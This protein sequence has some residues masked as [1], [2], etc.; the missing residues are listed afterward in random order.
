MI[1]Q[2]LLLHL[3]HVPG[4][5]HIVS[6]KPADAAEAD[7]H[8]FEDLLMRL[9]VRLKQQTQLSSASKLAAAVTATA[10]LIEASARV[11]GFTANRGAAYL[12]VILLHAFFHTSL[13]HG[14]WV[15]Q[16]GEGEA[17]F[18]VTTPPISPP[19][20]TAS[21]P[22]PT[23]PPPPPPSVSSSGTAKTPSGAARPLH[24][25]PP[26]FMFG[27]GTLSPHPLLLA[28]L[29]LLHP[30][31]LLVAGPDPLWPHLLPLVEPVP[32]PLCPKAQPVEVAAVNTTNRSAHGI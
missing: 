14:V 25:P 31:P 5:V 12:W 6:V 4:G 29:D 20:R 13:L 8:E 2:P 30:H 10:E 11:L 27:S 26:L 15:T 16:A 18:G 32:G 17:G 7:R 1:L 24:H 21:P 9:P 19:P 3:I 23:P 22:P 28:R